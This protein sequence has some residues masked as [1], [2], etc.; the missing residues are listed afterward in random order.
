MPAGTFTEPVTMAVSE[1]ALS[2]APTTQG[3]VS[4]SFLA[5]AYLINTQ[6]QE[7]QSGISVTITLPYNPALAP[8][9]PTTANMALSYYNGSQW[10]VLT[11]IAVN[12]TN[13]TVTVV[14]NHFSWWAVVLRQNTPTPAPASPAGNDFQLYPNPARGTQ[15]N[16]YVPGQGG[17]GNL[18]V[19]IF[20]IGFRRAQEATISNV[21]PGASIDL[22]LRDKAGVTLSNGLYYVVVTTP[23]G[24]R[25]IL[26]LLVLH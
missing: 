22:E 25:F 14:T 18:K 10:V 6:G 3:V 13:D 4:A 8:S 20:T 24:E 2:S 16:I 15:V 5:N 12:T 21:V 9:N 1:Y 26:K 23:E 19:E 17:P 11:P 7:P